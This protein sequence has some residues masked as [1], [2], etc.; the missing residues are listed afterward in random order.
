MYI[1]CDRELDFLV[2]SWTNVSIYFFKNFRG[3]SFRC[4]QEIFQLKII[5]WWK[6]WV[7]GFPVAILFSVPLLIKSPVTF[8]FTSLMEG[9]RDVC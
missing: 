6:P 2:I 9:E 1:Y 4:L 7:F 8:L 5:F 3:Y